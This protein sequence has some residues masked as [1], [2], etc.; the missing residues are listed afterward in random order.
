MNS[1]LIFDIG[2][3]E[4]EDTH[5]YLYK[6][7]R[8]VAVDAVS[9]MIECGALLFPEEVATGRL[10]LE[11]AVI[12][13]EDNTTVPFYISPNS[14]WSSAHREIAERQGLHAERVSLPAITLRSL[15]DKYGVPYYCKIDIEGNDILALNSLKG[16]SCLPQYISV[17][18]ECIGD[19][20]Y[21]TDVTFTTLDTLKDLGYTR[22]KLIDQFSLQVLDFKPFYSVYLSEEL[23]DTAYARDLL[24]VKEGGFRQYFPNSSGP[25]G[26]DLRGRWFDYAEARELIAYHS[27]AQRKQRAAVWSFWCDWHATR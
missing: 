9:E 24:Q 19:Q 14:L 1:N 17:E 5:Y 26:E 23:D 20:A 27:K 7:Y 4:G 16:A 13:A 6:G 12:S 21:D 18:T 22:F 25:F 11:Q 3:H 8:V 2:F 10:I 15:M